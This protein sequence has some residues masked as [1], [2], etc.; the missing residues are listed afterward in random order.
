M[1]GRTL[2]GHG[3]DA[4][5]GHKAFHDGNAHAGALLSTGREHGTAGL[6]KVRDAAAAVL[7]HN[8]Q[9]IVR[10][11]PRPQD[12]RPDRL[13]VGVDDAVRHGLGHGRLDVAQLVER[14]VELR[15]KAGNGRARK[16][17]IG[18]AAGKFQIHVVFALHRLHSSLISVIFSMPAARSTL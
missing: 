16:G 6:L 10:Q 9:H 17:L 18:R 3:A 1:D 5:L 12:D 13:G 7:D 2:A 4:E 15:G 11:Q 8:V 14:R